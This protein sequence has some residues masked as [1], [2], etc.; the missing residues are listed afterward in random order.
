MSFYFKIET[1]FAKA[2]KCNIC[3]IDVL[4]L[5]LKLDDSLS[6]HK[7]VSRG[8]KLLKMLKTVLVKISTFSLAL[9]FKKV[10]CQL[11]LP[12]T[13]FIGSELATF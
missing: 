7:I 11:N 13:L 2:I 3:C 5:L 8:I 12:I 9:V 6:S 4:V 10:L 1:N